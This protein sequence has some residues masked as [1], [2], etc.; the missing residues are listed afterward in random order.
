ISAPTEDFPE[1]GTK[2][3]IHTR[4]ADDLFA[5]T[6]SALDQLHLTIHDSRIVTSSNDWTLNT[7]IVLDDEDQAIR[8]RERIE[9][10]R[11]H[12]IEELDDPDD[13]PNIVTRH[14]PRQLKHF[15]VPTQ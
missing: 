10:I 5:A 4:S 11:H 15:K 8:D 7:F 6:A 3:F 13:Y 1:G 2:V 9:A 12:L 14:T